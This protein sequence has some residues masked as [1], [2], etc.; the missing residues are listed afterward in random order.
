MH[1]IA[2]DSD[3]VLGKSLDQL[4]AFVLLHAVMNALHDISVV[5]RLDK[6]IAEP[7]LLTVREFK[8]EMNT[9]RLCN[10]FFPAVTSNVGL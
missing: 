2:E 9:Q 1:T 8:V 4:A 3:P 6:L 5:D 10:L 7:R